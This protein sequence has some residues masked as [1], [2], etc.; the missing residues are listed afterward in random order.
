MT[1]DDVVNK[2]VENVELYYHA[3]KKDSKKPVIW[4]LII[5]VRYL[6][7]RLKAT[8][9]YPKLRCSI[10][11]CANLPVVFTQDEEKLYCTY[12]SQYYGYCPSCGFSYNQVDDYCTRCEHYEF[13]QYKY[14]DFEIDDYD[15][16]YKWDDR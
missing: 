13:E 10:N 16:D 15:K 6:N 14:L 4:D 5:A 1:F 3:H 12:H 9:K 7:H 11:G 2:T 8:N